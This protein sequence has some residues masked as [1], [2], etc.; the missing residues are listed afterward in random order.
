MMRKSLIALFAAALASI[1]SAATLS[2]I[3]LLNPTGSTAGQAI[4]SMGPSTAPGWATVTAGGITPIAAN[5]VY[6]NFTGAS[7]SPIANAVP[8]CSTGNSA[9]K[10][11][12][13]TGFS[14]GAT[15]ALT[16]GNLSQFAATTSAQL[17]GALSDE[18]GTGLAVF[19]T[20]PS[21]TTPTIAGGALSGTFSGTPTFS[22]AV[23]FS[24][25][26]AVTS[27]G[28]GSGTASGARTNLGLG[29]IATQNA[30]AVAITGGSIDGAA[31]GQV[32]AAAG[33]F[34]NVQATGFINPSQTS[35]LIGT[36]TNNNASAGSWGEYQSASPVGISL[37]NSTDTNITSISLTAGDWDVTGNVYFT[38]GTGDTMTAGRVSVSATSATQAA[39]PLYTA[40]GGISVTPGNEVSGIAPM[41]RF[42]VSTTTTVFLVATGFHSGGTLTGQGI[43]RARRV[44]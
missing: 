43:V 42:S 37:T 31:I 33:T 19:G 23:T 35:G 41:Q 32:T 18:T 12:S 34:T 5:S 6:A 28:T 13:G 20:S 7:A 40:I 44:R 3:Q 39:V 17:A 15:F 26:V 38:T 16:S 30:S 10:Y 25:A 21:L 36:T 4:V 24:T 2:P 9:L 14:C 27:G 11:T 22:G 8:S 1:A 29:T